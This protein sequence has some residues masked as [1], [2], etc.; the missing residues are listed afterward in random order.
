MW[1]PKGAGAGDMDPTRGMRRAPRW[2]GKAPSG[3][4]PAPIRCGSG[5]VA[6]GL[7]RFVELRS[8]V[9]E[10]AALSGWPGAAIGHFLRKLHPPT[11]NQARA[12]PVHDF[13]RSLLDCIAGSLI[14]AK[15]QRGEGSGRGFDRQMGRGCHFH[16]KSWSRT[17]RRGNDNVKGES[18]NRSKSSPVLENER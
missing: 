3:D 17:G 14:G 1:Q 18:R 10:D 6:M 12:Y 7:H 11:A 2:L 4:A 9:E 13:V 15:Q 16:F 8:G 5:T